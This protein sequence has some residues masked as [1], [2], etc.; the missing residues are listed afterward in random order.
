MP[1]FRNGDRGNF[2]VLI[3]KTC[4]PILEI[5]PT[6]FRKDDNIR[7]NDYRHLSSGGINALRALLKS[8]RQARDSEGVRLM[9]SS[10]F[11]KS[12]PLHTFSSTGTSRANRLPFFIKIKPAF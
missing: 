7:I 4:A 2:K 6:L 5:E 8:V 3:Q 1:K 10:A 11:T 12:R 9:C